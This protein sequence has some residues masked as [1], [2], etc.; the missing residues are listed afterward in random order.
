MAK[1][2]RAIGIKEDIKYRIKGLG[3]Y[4]LEDGMNYVNSLLGSSILFG[5]ET[6]YNTKEAEYRLIERIEEDML[7]RIFETGPGCP[8]FH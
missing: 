6:I 5:A 1:Q 4:T 3:Q 2:N 7:R 8:I